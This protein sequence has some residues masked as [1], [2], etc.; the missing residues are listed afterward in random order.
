MAV[1]LFAG[2]E[3]AKRSYR[4]ERSRFCENKPPLPPSPRRV[5]DIGAK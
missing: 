5:D 3:R 4:A 1:D 2:A